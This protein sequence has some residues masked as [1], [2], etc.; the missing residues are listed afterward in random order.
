MTAAIELTRER[1]L[2]A[3]KRLEPALRS[4]GVAHLAIFGSRARGDNRPD[5]DL[6][7]LVDVVSTTSRNELFVA[8]DAKDLISAELG[9]QVDAIL[10][11]QLAPRVAGR[12][13]DD[14]TEVF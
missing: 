12:A 3:L 7:V 11:G 10:R 14:I 6:D 5:S 2:D 1:I 8:F 9:L 4:K 13:A